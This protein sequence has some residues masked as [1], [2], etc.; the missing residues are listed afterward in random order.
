M[1][2]LDSPIST[3]DMR[4]SPEAQKQA[5]PGIVLPEWMQGVFL[6]IARERQQYTRVFGPTGPIHESAVLI[7]V[8]DSPEPLCST[9][10]RNRDDVRQVTRTQATADRELDAL[11]KTPSP[12]L[13]LKPIHRNWRSAVSGISTTTSLANGQMSDNNPLCRELKPIH[14]FSTPPETR[15]AIPIVRNRHAP[16][17]PLVI[18]KEFR[19]RIDWLM[20]LAEVAVRN[21][22]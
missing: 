7:E 9:F 14:V 1:R 6:K 8:R 13:S 12:P 16:T 2:N 15:V 20:R 4:S 17:N 10:V 19:E 3:R 21:S 5:S 18:V 22:G 11:E